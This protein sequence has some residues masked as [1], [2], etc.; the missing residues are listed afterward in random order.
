MPKCCAQCFMFNG[1]GCKATM[2]LF[3]DWFNICA[4]ASN[5]PIIEI[6]TAKQD[7]ILNALCNNVL[8]DSEIKEMNY[9]DD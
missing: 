8:S 5:C 7:V 4:R 3:P 2:Q 1:D 9:N 6:P